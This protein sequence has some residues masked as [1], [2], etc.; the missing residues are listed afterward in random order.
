MGLSA[1]VSDSALVDDG[2]LPKSAEIARV[3]IDAERDNSLDAMKGKGKGKGDG[4]C[5]TCGGE[6]YF[7]RCCPSV[8]PVGPQSTECHGCHVRGQ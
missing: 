7:A 2:L 8:A 4:R 5:H 3:P 1:L 6:G